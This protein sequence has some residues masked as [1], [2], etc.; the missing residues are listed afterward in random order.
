MQ[1]YHVK[2]KVYILVKKYFIVLKTASHHLSLH[3]F[4]FFAG[5]RFKILW[6]LSNSNTKIQSGQ[7]L[8]KK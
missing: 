3:K 5:E 7:M 8:F 4:Y 1:Q 6:E 2:K